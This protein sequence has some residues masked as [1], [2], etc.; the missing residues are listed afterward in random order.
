[1]SSL[2]AHV[3][4]QIAVTALRS[5]RTVRRYLDGLPVQALSAE[6]IERALSTLGLAGNGERAVATLASGR[7]RLP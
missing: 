1:M 4:R 5:P 2:S 7:G 3:I 6:A